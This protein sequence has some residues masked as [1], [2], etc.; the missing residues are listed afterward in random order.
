MPQIFAGTDFIA[1]H[2]LQLLYFRETALL[3]TVKYNFTVNTNGIAP[4]YFRWFK[5]HAVQFVIKRTEQFL[6]HISSPE[7]PVAFWAVLNNN[8]WFHRA[9]LQI[10]RRASAARIN[11]KGAG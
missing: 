2:L 1:Y 6:G 7:Q 3:L 8:G 10:G 5:H 9:N 4:G 11:K